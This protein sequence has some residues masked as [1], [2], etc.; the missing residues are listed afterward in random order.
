MNLEI[1][2][3]FHLSYFMS[4]N[5]NGKASKKW[6]KDC[7]KW[8]ILLSSK[9]T[10][11]VI[12]SYFWAKF[13][14][15]LSEIYGLS[16]EPKKGICKFFSCKKFFNFILIDQFW[17]IIDIYKIDKVFS[18]ITKSEIRREYSTYD[19]IL[20]PFPCSFQTNADRT[21]HRLQISSPG[22]RARLAR[23]YL[24]PRASA[25]PFYAWN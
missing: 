10:C 6:L 4:I 11:N 15:F 23:R 2:I 13:L 19:Q 24:C 9:V 18:Q 1:F 5:S 17:V 3:C 25:A 7:Q 14:P 12:V 16:I 20:Y 21:T 8:P 22:G